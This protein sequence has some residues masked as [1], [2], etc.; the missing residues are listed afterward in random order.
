MKCHVKDCKCE[1]ATR[2]WNC[3]A[4]VCYQH[5]DDVQLWFTGKPVR[6]CYPCWLKVDLLAI[7]RK[8]LKLNE[9]LK[10]CLWS[11]DKR[12]PSSTVAINDI[13]YSLQISWANAC[14]PI[15][16]F[17]VLLI[18]AP[19]VL[20]AP[21]CLVI[22]AQESAIYLLEESQEIPAF[23]ISCGRHVPVQRENRRL[24]LSIS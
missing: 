2:C 3:W 11:L 13:V 8:G 14:S 7:P 22:N 16:M 18:H 21:A 5:S 23:W 19:Q 15:Q 10:N 6:T 4:P 12:Y 17:E 9:I 1:T 20:E 24:L